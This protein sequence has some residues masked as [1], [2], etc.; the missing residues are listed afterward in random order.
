MFPGTAALKNIDQTLQTIRNDV[1]RLDAELSRVTDDMAARQR[2]RLKIIN[3]MAVVRL[4]E[5]ESGALGE[6]LNSA[7]RQAAHLLEQRK[8]AL[9]KLNIDIEEINSKIADAEQVRAQELAAVNELSQRVVDCEAQ[10]QEQLKLNDDYLAQLDVARAAESVAAEA[11][12]KVDLAQEDMAEKAKPYQDD[13]LFMYLWQRGYGT[14]EYSAGLFA[15]FMDGW[16]ARTIKYEPARVNFWNLTEI[17]KRLGEHADRVAN[18]ADEEYMA[19]QQIELDAL[20]QAGAKSLEAELATQREKL[21]KQDDELE[22]MEEALNEVLA[23]RNQFYSGGDDY[24]SRC[25][26]ELRDAL[27]HRDLQSIRVY[28]EETSSMTDDQLLIDLR[29]LDQSMD[30]MQGDLK[31]IRSLHD[32]K[33][34]R[35]SELEKVRRKFKNSRFDDVRSGF[36]NESLLVG[37]LGQFLQGLVSGSDVWRVIK[38]NQRYRDIASQP[39]FGSGSLGELGDLLG[40]T[41]GGGG[42]RRRR[43]SSWH[44][45]RPRRG[46]GGFNIPSGGGRSRGGFK[47]GGGF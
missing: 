38:R 8:E 25:I 1:V 44:I 12:Q 24:L 28:V 34:S 46:G 6:S 9:L 15:R 37:V 14:T 40:D 30:N 36:G 3:D 4:Q 18:Q 29:S 19:L 20:E 31:D 43:N 23:Q 32:N 26:K 7:D 47:T 17:P 2:Q 42:K 10:V 13:P 27:D 21:D 41:L 5:I 33:V 22:S 11:Q 35:L 45:P 16:V 39:D